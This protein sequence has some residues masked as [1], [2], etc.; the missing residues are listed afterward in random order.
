MSYK[1]GLEGIFFEDLSGYKLT[2]EGFKR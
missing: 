2:N 1:F